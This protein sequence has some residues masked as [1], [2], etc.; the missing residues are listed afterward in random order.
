ME[1]R[2]NNRICTKGAARR[3]MPLTMAAARMPSWLPLLGLTAL[4]GPTA[5]LSDVELPQCLVD[6]NCGGIG[7]VSSV[8]GSGS[9]QSG[10]P[11]GAAGAQ[12]SAGGS[13]DGGDLGE[14]GKPGDGR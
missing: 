8:G 12:V 14:G 13:A 9:N 6:H 3:G 10:L 1:Q 11:G 2:M 4:G 7:G 5:C